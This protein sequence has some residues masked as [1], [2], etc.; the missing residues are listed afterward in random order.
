M[1]NPLVAAS[2]YNKRPVKADALDLPD[3]LTRELAIVERALKVATNYASGVFNVLDY[4]A[5]PTGARDSTDALNRATR[6]AAGGVLSLPGG[7]TFRIADA[8][9][10]ENPVTISMVGATVT[11]RTAARAG[12]SLVSS[13]V[14]VLGGTLVGP[15]YAAFQ[16]G[17][18]GLYALAPSWAEK[19]ENIHVVGT[20][21][22]T[23]GDSGIRLQWVDGFTLE[24]IVGADLHYAG[25]MGYGVRSGI[26]FGG[27]RLANIPGSADTSTNAYG[28][29]LTRGNGASLVTDPISEH[30][31]VI[32]ATVTDVPTWNGFDTHGGADITFVGCT[33]LRCDKGFWA[34]PASSGATETW[35]PKRVRFLGCET[36][37]GVDDGSAGVGVVI[38]GAASGVG[39]VVDYADGCEVDDCT[40]RRHGSGATTSGGVFFEFAT[41]C[42]HNG[43]T[44]DTCSPN[45]TVLHSDCTVDV[46]DV[47]YVD[48]WDDTNFGRAIR[49]QD[50][51]V[52]AWIDGCSLRRGTKS[53]TYVNMDAVTV[54]SS[55]G[56]A[57]IT[58]GENDWSGVTTTDTVR[59]LLGTALTNVRTVTTTHNVAP[60]DQLI[61]AD[62][63]GGAFNVNLSDVATAAARV[64]TI[65]KSDSS[66]NAV[67]VDAA[68][69]DLIYG[70]GAG[71]GTYALATQGK[72]VTLES[73][74]AGWYVLAAL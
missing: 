28:I 21:L 58:L 1:T 46:T 12:L 33:A 14:T 34:V 45:G 39:A 60:S 59:D 66:A 5:D 2:T 73:N 6:E 51:N 36:D 27:T 17:G 69:T 54:L 10:A 38:S 71:A 4:G 74:G 9:V 22:S 18:V 29:T 15:Q 30:V 56:S 49:V 35:A 52:T 63:T 16:S 55:A 70:L 40:V 48:C 47:T 65:K 57:A 44:V 43:G 7:A 13:D 8:W 72:S 24:S 53:A 62:A 64:I 61:L 19:L 26:I 37:A 32:G 67:T 68:G 50:D 31:R 20:R 25:I 23:W 41:A 42:K 11:Q 3:F